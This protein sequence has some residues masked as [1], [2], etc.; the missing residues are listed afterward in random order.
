MYMAPERISGGKYSYP[1]D[2]WSLGL[3]IFACAIG[4]MPLPVNDGYWGVVHAVQQLPS[5]KL[6]DYGTFSRELCDFMDH[7]LKK[8]P[9]QRPSASQLLSHPFLRKHMSA[10]AAAPPLKDEQQARQEL[11]MVK[12][13]YHEWHASRHTNPPTF[14]TAKYTLLAKQLGLSPETVAAALNL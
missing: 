9:S 1:S 12:T 6:E 10:S 4:R 7:F 13:K 8:D 14:D 11:E 3:S 5:P 2:M